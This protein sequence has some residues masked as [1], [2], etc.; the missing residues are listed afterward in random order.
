MGQVLLCLSFG[1][2]WRSKRLQARQLQ[3]SVPF[4]SK[5]TNQ[6]VFFKK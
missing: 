5:A 1:R 2:V 4:L 6:N 3:P